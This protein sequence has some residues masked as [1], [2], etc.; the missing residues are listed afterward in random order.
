MISNFILNERK[1]LE[2]IEMRKPDVTISANTAIL[3]KSRSD[4]RAVR[5]EL[6]KMAEHCERS[7]TL[8]RN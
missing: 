1:C 8:S 3:N 5:I 4:R 2:E 6:I 7:V